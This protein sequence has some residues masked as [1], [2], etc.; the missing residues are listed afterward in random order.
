MNHI[1]PYLTIFMPYRVPYQSNMV[2]TSEYVLNM[3]QIWC[4]YGE[5]CRG[6]LQ[7]NRCSNYHADFS[8]LYKT[9]SHLNPP[10]PLYRRRMDSGV[11]YRE[12]RDMRRPY[13]AGRVGGYR[14]E[15][16][17][18]YREEREGVYREEREGGYMEERE[19]VYREE[20]LGD[21]EREETEGK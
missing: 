19:G 13:S 5:I 8:F 21:T 14:E 17:V 6:L 16:N 12:V 9:R 4:K 1:V 3:T 7:Y 2:E 20:R 18:R 10:E 15:M 11:H